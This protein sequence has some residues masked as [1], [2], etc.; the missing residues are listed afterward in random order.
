MVGRDRVRDVLQHHRLA[1]LGRCHQQAAL[2]LADRRDDVD[3]A[4][5]DVLLGL[6]VA[7]EDHR[8]VR[9][10]R[11]QVLEQDLVLGVLGR[12]AVDLV[13]LDQREVALA[14]LRR[15]DL[16]LDRVAGVQV[17][18]ADLRRRDVDVVGAGEV[19]R[20]GR[21]QEA[22]AVGQHLQHAVAEDVISPFFACCLSIAKMRSCL[23]IRFA[24][25]ISFALAN[26]ISS[27][28]CLDLRSER[29][30]CGWAC[31]ARRGCWPN[32]AKCGLEVAVNAAAKDNRVS[33][34]IL[35]RADCAAAPKQ[36]RQYGGV[37]GHR[38]YEG[39]GYRG[40]RGLS[41]KGSF[42]CRTGPARSDSGTNPALS[43]R[44]NNNAGA[45]KR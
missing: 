34:G 19:R 45:G 16:A 17:E 40:Y 39:Q 33:L 31:L 24:P 42:H 30:M 12:L 1:G 27:E 23:R 38:P 3:D 28:T 11:R 4:A 14:V 44:A 26:S 32:A 35:A 22:E 20:L 21:A 41:T 9:E 10:Q 29:C 13:D 36:F 7:L 43:D 2:A 6:D 8:L 5:G 37:Y 15:A 25:S 18:A